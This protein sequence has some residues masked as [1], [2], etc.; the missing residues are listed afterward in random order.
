ML[1]LP[2]VLLFAAIFTIPSILAFTSKSPKFWIIL[3][4]NLLGFFSGIFWFAALVVAVAEKGTETEV[5]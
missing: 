1:S 2:I 5:A 4:L 3:T